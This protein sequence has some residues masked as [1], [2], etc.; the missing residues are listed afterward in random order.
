[1]DIT[2][3]NNPMTT[4]PKSSELTALS[5]VRLTEQ[6]DSFF[7]ISRRPLMLAGAL[8]VRP[9][10]LAQRGGENDSAVRRY[11]VNRNAPLDACGK[12]FGERDWSLDCILVDRRTEGRE[13]DINL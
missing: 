7:Q 13:I 5:L 11:F 10:Q 9:Q 4:N 1:M 12:Q 3:K 8:G 2:L 6:Q